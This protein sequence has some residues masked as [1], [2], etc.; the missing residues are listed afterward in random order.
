V[1]LHILGLL[2]KLRDIEGFIF[3]DEEKGVRPGMSKLTPQAASLHYRL[4]A[5]YEYAENS[6]TDSRRVVRAPGHRGGLFRAVTLDIR[7][8]CQKSGMR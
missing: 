8:G 4:G 1:L 2:W 3:L 5:L 7:C 6:E